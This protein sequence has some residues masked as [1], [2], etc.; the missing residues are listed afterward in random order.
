MK[1]EK[2]RKTIEELR[3]NFDGKDS[4]IAKWLSNYIDCRNELCERCGKYKSVG[5]CDG[6]RYE[7]EDLYEQYR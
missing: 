2:I 1:I 7:K 3:S 6:C 4:E 5:G